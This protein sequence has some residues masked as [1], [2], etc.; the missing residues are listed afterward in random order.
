MPTRLLSQPDATH[1][2]ATTQGRVS[3]KHGSPSCYLYCV[4]I[5]GD[6]ALSR[7]TILTQYNY[8]ALGCGTG[9]GDSA[10]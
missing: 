7:V 9:I 6:A 5:F 8:L 2:H 10:K 1:G 3:C 4:T